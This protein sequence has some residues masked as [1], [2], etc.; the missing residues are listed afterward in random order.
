MDKTPNS[1]DL[2]RLEK[3]QLCKL[4]KNPYIVRQRWVKIK[5]KRTDTLCHTKKIAAQTTFREN[6]QLLKR[7]LLGIK[8]KPTS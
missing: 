3:T 4:C 6:I 5:G 7:Q 8:E 2:K 1:E